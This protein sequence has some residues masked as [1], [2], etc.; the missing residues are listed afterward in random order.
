MLTIEQ[1]KEEVIKGNVNALY[2]SKQWKKKR[3]DILKRDHYECQ[4]CKKNKHILTYANTV[5]HIIELKDD[6][7]RMLDDNNLESV[8]M[9]CHNELH[10]EKR[11]KYKRKRFINE[12][13][14]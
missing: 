6:A 3:I 1:I 8:C 5:H 9:I 13:K 2:K 14:W 4:R 11:I 7:D 12:E 10:P